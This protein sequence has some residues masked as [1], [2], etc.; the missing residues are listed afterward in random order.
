MFPI[1]VAKF[2]NFVEVPVKV[3]PPAILEPEQE[4]KATPPVID[5][6]LLSLVHQSVV[7][8]QATL[9]DLLVAMVEMEL[10]SLALTVGLEMMPIVGFKVYINTQT[11]ILALNIKNL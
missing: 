9:G 4:E 8:W 7:Q 10:V 5:P 1:S 2:K 11:K 6:V 3:A